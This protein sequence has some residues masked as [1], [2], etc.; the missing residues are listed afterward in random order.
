MATAGKQGWSDKQKWVMYLIGTVITVVLSV[1]LSYVMAQKTAETTA[2]VTTSRLLEQQSEQGE[3]VLNSIGYRYF[4]SVALAID[5]NTG[6]F[7]ESPVHAYQKT[8]FETLKDI[9]EDLRW[10]Q[11]NPILIEKSQFIVDIPYLQIFLSLEL[12]HKMD[13]PLGNTVAIMCRSFV[14]SESWREP[15]EKFKNDD[16]VAALLHDASVVCSAPHN[17]T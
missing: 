9:L 8:Y 12:S 5:T 15:L 13:Q 7:T 11:K 14:E 2:Q 10:I 6:K 3:L 16:K 1:G 17:S 4:S